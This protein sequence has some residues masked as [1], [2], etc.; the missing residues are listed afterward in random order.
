MKVPVP[1]HIP[2]VPKVK[3]AT[4]RKV[5]I[6]L[7]AFGWLFIFI[8]L[9]CLAWGANHYQSLS[10][11]TAMW[12]GA[13]TDFTNGKTAC[14][15]GQGGGGTCR[16]YETGQATRSAP[17]FAAAGYIDCGDLYDAMWMNMTLA[18]PA[19]GGASI[20]P[21]LARDFVGVEEVADFKRDA[22]EAKKGT[23]TQTTSAMVICFA[24]A[25]AV[26]SSIAGLNEGRDAIS[27]AQLLLPITM[28]LCVVC[29]IILNTNVLHVNGAYLSCDGMST[30]AYSRLLPGPG[31]IPDN[32]PLANIGAVS[33]GVI[34]KLFENCGADCSNEEKAQREMTYYAAPTTQCMTNEEGDYGDELASAYIL[35]VTTAKA[36]AAMIFIACLFYVA[37]VMN[38]YHNLHAHGEP[39]EES[40]DNPAFSAAGPTP[41]VPPAGGAAAGGAPA[42]TNA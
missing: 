20:D 1:D 11:Q 38:A 26:A 32:N 41:S 28:A 30:N 8:G 7:V 36:G 13:S 9:I 14:P 29:F 23:F 22:C 34:A 33:V 27:V 2:Q 3:D 6:A 31:G 4:K 40:M 16:W 25:M 42:Y 21:N 24:I 37:V 35:A 5:T 19:S 15:G 17:L 12:G 10:G 39:R 18:P